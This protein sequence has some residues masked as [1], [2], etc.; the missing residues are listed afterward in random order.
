MTERAHGRAWRDHV[1]RLMP[2]LRARSGDVCELCGGEVDFAA[3]ARSSRS[4]SVDHVV[5]IHAGGDRLPPVDELRLVH[6]GCNSRRG[7]RTRRRGVASPVAPAVELRPAAEARDVAYAA[8]PR[9]RREPELIP[10]QPAL[11]ELDAE[12]EL[13]AARFSKP[14]V[15]RRQSRSPISPGNAPKLAELVEL[16]PPRLETPR[17]A[18][19]VGSYGPEACGW[20]TDY[21]GDELRPWQR[22]A[23]ERILEHRADGSL[24][25]RRVI[26]T[27]SRQSGKSVLSRG[28]CGWRVGA[29]DL[30][31][32][33]QEVLHVANLRATAARIWTPAA[34]RLEES[35]GAVVRR[36]NGQEA[37]ELADSSAWRLAASTLDGGVG[38]SVSLAFVDEAWRV[39]RD[40]VDG[41]IAP[42]MLERASPQLVLVSTAGDGGS[43][44]LLEDRD[45]AIAQIGEPDSARILLLEWSAPP[46]AYPDD[47]EAWRL[48]SPHWTP[49]RLEALEHAFATSS[50]ADWRRQYLN[51]WVLAARSWIAPAQWAEATEA[52]LELPPA[53]GTIAVN[54]QDG[55]PGACGYVLA[56]RDGDRV[57]VSGRAYPSRRAL[58][59]AL[60]ELTRGRRN[61]TLLY[62]PSF[63]QHVAQLRGVTAVKVG[64]AEQR[65]GYGPTLGAIVDG[66]LAHDGD[67]EL[68]RQ[69]LTATPVTVPDVGTTLS[70]RRSPGPIFLARAAVWAVGAEL[71]PET[72]PR[73]LVASA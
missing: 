60:E 66:R 72:R 38:S 12:L 59:A 36:A 42:T 2:E 55:R 21:L 26:L 35:A 33:P 68:T 3:R 61:V 62:P 25:W 23:L 6:Y 14:V 47:R 32:E 70:A 30:F 34:R 65:A 53:A 18:D 13:E 64:T 73:L 19:V 56:V 45:A 43:A 54:D 29:A 51:Q 28:L 20:I 41:S 1:A 7:N 39:S 46:E 57:L 27:V 11:F 67:A 5:P 22:Y 48:A 49:A 16:V 15:T 50:E 58:W 31:G 63:A 40:V 24:R 69:M 10:S 8:P 52:E 44:L 9:R 37:I 71:R 4:P 17:P